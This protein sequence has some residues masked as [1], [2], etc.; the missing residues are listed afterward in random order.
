MALEHID[1]G[2]ALYNSQRQ[3][4]RRLGIGP[5]PA[6]VGLNASAL[7]LWTGGYADRAYNRAAEAIALAR[8]LNHPYSLTYAQFH[9]GLLNMWLKNYEIARNSADAVLELAERYW[10]QIWSA[11]GSC[12]R[13]AALVNIGEIDEGLALTQHGLQAYRG[14][15]TPPVFWPLLL[16]LCAGACGA[17]SRPK[18]GLHLLDEAMAAEKFSSS[19]SD[20]LAP[21]FLILKGDLL[22]AL[23]SDNAVDAGSLYQA[24]LN[25]AREVG[26][27]MV[28]LQAAMRLSRLW[29][30]QGKSEQ[31]RELLSTAYSK[32]TEGFSTADMKEAK[33]LLATRSS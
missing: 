11:I 29:Q 13:G 32:I 9:N 27:A 8:K 23:S 1:K 6:V 17:A 2:I 25:S 18:D 3:P 19:A 7:F 24:A 10:F 30:N 5:N 33:A 12:L 20:S 28:E 4:A 22:L 15:R 31:A 26:A 21:E 16:H 14:L